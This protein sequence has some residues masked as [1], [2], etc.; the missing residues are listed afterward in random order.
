VAFPAGFVWGAAA[1]AYQIEGAASDDG[2]GPSVWDAFCLEPGAIWGGHNGD[3]A[4]DHYRRYPDDVAIMRELGIKAYRTSISWSR[5]LPEGSGAPNEKGLAFY[6]RLIDTLLA[7]GIQ[8]YLTLFHWDFPLALYE[9]GGWLNR[10]SASWFADYAELV[11][12]RL[13]DRVRDWLTLNEPQV[14]LGA[15]HHEG[16]HAPGDRLP[17]GQVL[18]AGHH[19]LLAHGLAVRA[20]RAMTPTPARVGFAPVARVK[21]PASETARDVEAAERA[22]FSVDR[23]TPWT[24]SW[25][26]DP[27]YLGRYPEDGLATFG[28]DAPGV[29]AGDLETISQPL[30]HCGFNVYEAEIVRAGEDGQPEVVPFSVG[31]PL[32]SFDFRVTPSALYW[33]PV[34]FHRRYGLP[35]L[36]TENG[37]SCRDWI[38]QDGQVHDPQRIDFMARH[39]GAL[40]RAGAEGIPLLG[41]F[42][43]SILDNF[44]WAHGYKHR[45]GL[46]YVD[47]ATQR[48]VP[49]DSAHW[50]REVIRTNGATL[51]GPADFAE[52]S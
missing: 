42:H 17:L 52:Q 30:D 23:P 25:W 19:A 28:A 16:R 46:V 18:T 13:G 12:K 31:H 33:A 26:L 40:R 3:V 41:Y 10:D 39:L 4:C 5:V 35:I 14:F 37:L 27:V 20:I 2:R 49:K 21:V 7:A 44:E 22:T 6:D 34:F 38:S 45:F 29:A 51:S 32:T 50:Y 36:I 9:R 11:V 24:N 48:R 8:P 47:Y 1:A 43:W 15:G